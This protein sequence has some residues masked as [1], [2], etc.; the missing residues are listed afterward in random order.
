MRL[1]DNGITAV[2]IQVHNSELPL[3]ILETLPNPVLVKDGEL[4]YVW[5][6]AAFE[7]LF[8]VCLDDLIGRHDADVFKKRQAV[9][10]SGSDLRVLET[11][12]VN[13]SHE[14]VF[15]LDGSA[16]EIITRKSR[17][18][19]SDGGH[20]LVGVLHDIT[21]VKRSNEKLRA[22]EKIL[23]KQSVQLQALA[24]TDPLTECLNRRALFDQV[25]QS[26]DGLPVKYSL[27]ALDLDYFKN[28]N[29][30][31]GH[32]A[33]DAALVHF[34]TLIRG[35]IRE[36]DVFARVGGEEFVIV[37][38]NVKQ[39][40]A[41]LVADRICS[42]VAESPLHYDEHEISITVSIGVGICDTGENVDFSDV[43]K[44]ADEALYQAKDDGR[45]QF[46]AMVHVG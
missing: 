40:V 45:N 42:Q 32:D 23:K 17:L 14:T 36:Q 30:E 12:D 19:L 1:E 37:L 18:T 9:Q 22:S 4:R 29:D 44:Q 33:G 7:S 16:V 15:T 41:N 38:P 24:D 26:M 13:E 5:V 8:G 2:M 20:Y 34:S 6:N 21:D 25:S 3:A 35:L 46:V 39:H 11:D 31:F 27:L 10:C 28:I 43:M